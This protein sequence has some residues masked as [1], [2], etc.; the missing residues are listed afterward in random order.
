MQKYPETNIWNTPA[1]ATLSASRKHFKLSCLQDPSNYDT[2]C[3]QLILPDTLTSLHLQTTVKNKPSATSFLCTTVQ[4][5]LEQW[6]RNTR[7]ENMDS[8]QHNATEVIQVH[9]Q[10]SSANHNGFLVSWKS[11]SRENCLALFKPASVA[12]NLQHHSL[13]FTAGREKSALCES[14]QDAHRNLKMWHSCKQWCCPGVKLE[15]V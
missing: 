1:V 2:F 5:I 11:Y 14:V 10:E 13:W 15:I 6:V 4:P 3:L 9:I 12:K 8:S 7:T